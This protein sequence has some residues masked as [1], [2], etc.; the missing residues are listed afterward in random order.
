[1]VDQRPVPGLVE[2]LE[3]RRDKLQRS[4]TFALKNPGET[5]EDQAET[6]RVLAE[7]RAEKAQVETELSR[8]SAAQERKVEIPTRADV[9]RLLKDLAKVLTEATRSDD[10]VE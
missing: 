2:K 5:D 6:K 7:L 8:I 4:I 10:P 9:R 1:M 3:V